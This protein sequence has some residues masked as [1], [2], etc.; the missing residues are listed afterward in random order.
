MR[1]SA[2]RP[3]L[4]M[5]CDDA[6]WTVRAR[7]VFKNWLFMSFSD[8]LSLSFFSAAC[9]NLFSSEVRKTVEVLDT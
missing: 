9:K 3:A 6:L 7:A 8:F 5:V 2:H 1:V 4:Q